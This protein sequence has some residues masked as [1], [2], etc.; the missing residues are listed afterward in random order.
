MKKILAILG[1]GLFLSLSLYADVQ[2]VALHP[3]SINYKTE[4]KN[5]AVTKFLVDQWQVSLADTVVYYNT[6]NQDAVIVD[7]TWQN[8]Y[9]LEWHQVYQMTENEYFDSRYQKSMQLFEYL[10][11]QSK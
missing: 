8:Q 5:V 3:E 9:G 7:E 1:A 11:A 6:P 10:Q 2:T 4:K